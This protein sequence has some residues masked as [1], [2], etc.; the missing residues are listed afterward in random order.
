M[1][2]VSFVIKIAFPYLVLFIT[3][4]VVITIATI[5]YFEKFTFES[6]K[7]ELLTE[8]NLAGDQILQSGSIDDPVKIQELAIRLAKTTG[9]RITIIRLDG[10][11]IG[12]SAKDPNQLE[13][14]L[15]RPEI[16]S[17]L[18]GQANTVIRTSTTIHERLLYAAAPVI[19][20]G[21]IIAVVRLA[22]TIAVVDNTL[23]RYRLF[24]LLIASLSLVLCL[25]IILIQSSKKFNPL[26]HISEKVQQLSL[27]N[28]NRIDIKTNP[29]EIGTI[30]ASVNSMVDRI[31]LQLASI[32]EERS[33]NNTILAN[34]RDGVILVD[35]SGMVT[36]INP[37]AQILFKI[38]QEHALGRS[39]A[40]VVRHYQVLEIWRQCKE[41]QST[42]NSF[43]QISKDQE[44]VQVIA[45]PI[46][47]NIIGN[48][49]LIFHDLTLVRKLQTIRQ[50]FVSNVSH[51]LK[52]PLTSLKILVETLLD[53]AQKT[54]SEATHF[55]QQMEIEIDNLTQIVQELLDLSKIESG[56]VPLDLKPVLPHD[57]LDLPLQRMKV[58]AQR[59]GIELVVNC[60]DDLPMVL[61]DASRL[62]QVIINLL[63]NAIKFTNPGG[64]VTIKAEQLN[65]Q[66]GFSIE[67]T[68]VGISSIDLP[69]IFERFFKAD[70]ARS[71]SGTGLGLS[72][73][74]H[75]VECHGG[76]IWVESELGKGSKFSFTIP[77]AQ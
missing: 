23:S 6:A 76:K 61:A 1:K 44:S 21:E 64:K 65:G 34:M 43:V 28:L 13:N 41:K 60:P 50:D 27:G 69:R 7:N 54:P 30:V 62:Q 57:L 71:S 38:D 10:I 74:R 15:S 17:A 67:D 4:L 40:E 66:V 9:D 2:K 53:G 75:I 73:A 72:I 47:E 14:H 36:L 46:Q 26:F 8:T 55:L 39:L 5:S 18:G 22:K 68:G 56:K 59:A 70:R 12:E 32:Q 19:S 51:E 45:S 35:T 3:V 77:L 24:V 33:K 16:Q 42:Q 20:N 52:T 29:D 48:V 37:A 11:V 58:Q 49:L 63:H 31:A 25:L